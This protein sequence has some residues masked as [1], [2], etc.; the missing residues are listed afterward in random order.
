MPDR[1][2]RLRRSALG[3]ETETI[4]EHPLT[5]SPNG[6]QSDVRLASIYMTM[7]GAT[8]LAVRGASAWASA[9]AHAPSARGA[10]REGVGGR[11]ARGATDPG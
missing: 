7:H 10:L 6:A 5:F 1:S 4:A 2:H 9:H 3:N 11:I 8:S